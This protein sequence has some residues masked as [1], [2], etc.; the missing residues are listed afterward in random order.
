MICPSLGASASK[1][2]IKE[3]MNTNG[4]FFTASFLDLTPGGRPRSRQDANRKDAV[5][6]PIVAQ[7]LQSP[8]TAMFLTGH[9]GPS[10]PAPAAIPGFRWPSSTRVVVFSQAVGTGRCRSLP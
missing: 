5:R 10:N 1:L 4:V 2:S 7:P 9:A 3:P 6:M 8:L